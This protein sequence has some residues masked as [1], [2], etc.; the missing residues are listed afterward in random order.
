MLHF[1]FY[2]S[3]EFGVEIKFLKCYTFYQ[4]KLLSL[5]ESTYLIQNKEPNLS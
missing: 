2:L 4:M 3:L 5:Y 1:C